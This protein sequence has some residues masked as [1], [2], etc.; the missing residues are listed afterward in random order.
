MIALHNRTGNAVDEA[1]Q[2]EKP[3]VYYCA[4]VLAVL[5]LVM[6]KI[7]AAPHHRRGVYENTQRITHKE[8]T[9]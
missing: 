8:E 6:P 9:E 7:A 2:R 4:I 3:L 1:K 5:P